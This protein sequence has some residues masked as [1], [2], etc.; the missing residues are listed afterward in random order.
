MSKE[1]RNKRNLL[2][3]GYQLL[4]SYK[5]DLKNYLKRTSHG[6]LVI[7]NL[8]T[9]LSYHNTILNRANCLGKHNFY[10]A[11]YNRCSNTA[12]KSITRE[13][14]ILIQT[15]TNILS[16]KDK[17]HINVFLMLTHLEY[18]LFLWL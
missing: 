1:L 14:R 16:Y 10:L 3:S 2:L 4:R 13:G 6:K 5:S 11:Y 9:E 17:L 18:Y 12:T 7:S 8:L 15:K